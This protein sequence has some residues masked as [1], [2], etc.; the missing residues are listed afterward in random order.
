M[1][2]KTEQV[3]SL[4]T[5]PALPSAKSN[6]AC[7]T[8]LRTPLSLISPLLRRGSDL[9]IVTLLCIFA[10][11]AVS[12]TSTGLSPHSAQYKLVL[13][14]K[15]RF[16]TKAIRKLTSDAE[17]QWSVS[18]KASTFIASFSEITRFRL[19]DQGIT[20]LT[21]DKKSKV[22]TKKTERQLRYDWPGLQLTNG[23]QQW[24]LSL[25][26][27]IYDPLSYQLQLQLDLAQGKTSLSYQVNTG[28]QLETYQFER[29][30]NEK[31]SVGY[32]TLDTVHVERTYAHTTNATNE[33]GAGKTTRLWFAPSLNYQLVKLERVNQKGQTTHL[34]LEKML[35]R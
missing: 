11:P 26:Q 21:Y 28:E 30:G 18:L 2:A 4:A 32:G 31:V 29:L 8:D 35:S 10:L 3:S 6:I 19:D 9:I 27:P 34:T 16:E 12:D 1:M 24:P 15:G 20:P 23:E 22:F 7:C 33:K 14:G 13:D 5:P 25:A 17:Q